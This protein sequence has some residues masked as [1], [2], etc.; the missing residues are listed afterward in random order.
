MVIDCIVLIFLH[1]YYETFCPWLSVIVP[2]PGNQLLALPAI[3]AN[4]SSIEESCFFSLLF[5]PSKPGFPDHL[6]G[7]HVP[8]VSSVYFLTHKSASLSTSAL[9]KTS[10][11]LT[12][13]V[14]GIFIYSIKVTLHNSLTAFS[15]PILMSM[16]PFRYSNTWLPYFMLDTFNSASK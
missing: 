10:S 15:K 16:L 11:L 13:L 4:C 8:I 14:Q 7:V 2:H 6:F 9:W 1:H 5:F 3:P 12:L